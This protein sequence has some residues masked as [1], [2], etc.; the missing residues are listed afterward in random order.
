M[1]ERINFGAASGGK[2]FYLTQEAQAE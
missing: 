1:A 2:A